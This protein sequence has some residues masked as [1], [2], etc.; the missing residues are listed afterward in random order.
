[1]REASVRLVIYVLT[2]WFLVSI[3]VALFLGRV[4]R[5][6]SDSW[7]GESDGATDL[8]AIRGQGYAPAAHTVGSTKNN[9]W[10]GR[11]SAARA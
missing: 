3:P 4:F 5:L 6:N 1:M 7:V 2:V 8:A 10:Q 9:T 11:Q